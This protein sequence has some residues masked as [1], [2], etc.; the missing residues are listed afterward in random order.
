MGIVYG[1]IGT[2]PLNVFS[3]TFTGS[4]RH[5]DHILGVLSLI[6]YTLTLFKY[7]FVVLRANDNGDG[8][9]FALYSLICR[10]AKVGLLPNQQAED[11]QVSNYQLELPSSEM[12]R[13]SCLKS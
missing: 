6:F 8:G 13:A 10:Y 2:S 11:A 12:K 7:V 5:H 9:T 3:S 4:V 1:Y